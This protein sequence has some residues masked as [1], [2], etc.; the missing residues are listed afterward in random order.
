VSGGD[1]ELLSAPKPRA[2]SLLSVCPT[3]KP[4]GKPGAGNRHARFDERGWETGRCRMLKLPRPSSTLPT[5]TSRL[6]LAVTIL[7]SL[8]GLNV[9]GFGYCTCGSFRLGDGMRRRDFITILGG[10]SATLPFGAVAQEPGRIYRLGNLSP[11]PRDHP[12][13]KLFTANC[14]VLVSSR[15]KT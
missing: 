3:V 5:R 9:L 2:V 7:S 12:F 1:G 10:A 8:A 13:S 4:V 14:G 6:R 11:F 15:G